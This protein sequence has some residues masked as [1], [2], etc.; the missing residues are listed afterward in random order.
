M[1]KPSAPKRP[2]VRKPSNLPVPVESLPQLGS[3][4]LQP[5]AQA[6]P[7]IDA[8]VRE[9]GVEI[10]PRA[11]PQGLARLSGELDHWVK[12]GRYTKVR[13]KIGKKQI[14][15]DLPIAAAVAAEGL[16][17]LLTGPLQLL[18]ANVVGTTVLNIELISDAVHH[19][20]RG[21][22][23]ILAGELDAAL[24]QFRTAIAIDRDSA[25]AH[26]HIGIAL[27]LQGDRVGARLSFE[28]ASVLDPKG[29]S[30]L[31][32]AKLLATLRG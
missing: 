12:K 1:A 5:R 6:L 8:E 13:I 19:V 24:E 4:A 22:E 26:L 28:R 21:R 3:T 31:E 29:P 30:G 14:L 20:N 7:A 17:V 11:V 10:D 16:A 23:L 9:L 2:L 25:A 32:A 27:K 15:P 18:L